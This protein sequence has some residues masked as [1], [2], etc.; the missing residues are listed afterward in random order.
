MNVKRTIT[1]G[2]AAVATLG[3]AAV[4]FAGSAGA[5]TT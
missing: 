5:S 4:G 1:A 2:A 3:M